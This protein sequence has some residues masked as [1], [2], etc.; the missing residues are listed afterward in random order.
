MAIAK[1]FPLDKIPCFPNE[2]SGFSHKITIKSDDNFDQ[3]FESDK[4]VKIA[5]ID[6]NEIFSDSLKTMLQQVADFQVK[7]FKTVNGFYLNQ[8]GFVPDVLL[9]D[10]GFGKEGGKKNF[11]SGWPVRILLM[12]MFKDEVVPDLNENDLIL[13]SSSALEFE[14]KI[15]TLASFRK[16]DAENQCSVKK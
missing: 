7:T 5:I 1:G 11:G 13:K 4:M 16:Y 2:S 10:A 3:K 8:H 12:V 6:K 15:R 9:L 14:N